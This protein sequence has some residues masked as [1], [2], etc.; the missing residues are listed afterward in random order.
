LAATSWRRGEG[1]IR[2]KRERKER[3]VI[4]EGEED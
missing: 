1:R 2:K 3:V 4:R